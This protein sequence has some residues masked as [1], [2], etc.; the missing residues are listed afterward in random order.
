[1]MIIEQPLKKIRKCQQR[2]QNT[3][4]CSSNSKKGRKTFKKNTWNK[5]KTPRPKT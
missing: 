4:K 1:M 5:Y 2:R 3:E